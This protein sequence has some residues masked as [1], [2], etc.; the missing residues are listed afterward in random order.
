MKRNYYAGN[1]NGKTFVHV[2]CNYLCFRMNKFG[3]DIKDYTDGVLPWEEITNQVFDRSV[4]NDTLRAV[5]PN[6]HIAWHNGVRS[7]SGITSWNEWFYRGRG[8]IRSWLYKKLHRSVRMPNGSVRFI[9]S[10]RNW[11]GATEPFGPSAVVLDEDYQLTELLKD[12]SR[13]HIPTSLKHTILSDQLGYC[14]VCYSKI[15]LVGQGDVLQAHIDHIVPRSIAAQPQLLDR[16]ENY[17]ALCAECNLR[18]HTKS[19]CR[20]LVEEG[21]RTGRILVT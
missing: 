15:G 17:G 20:F 2:M 21:V 16:V 18:K 8:P 19:L 7:V 11:P 9:P 4:V 12:N 6:A 1:P 10:L 3:M 14:P 13:L 5:L